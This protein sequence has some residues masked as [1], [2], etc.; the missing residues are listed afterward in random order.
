MAMASLNPFCPA[1]RRRSGTEAPEALL[2]KVLKVFLGVLQVVFRF[3]L[4]SLAFR[5]R[6]Y[7]SGDDVAEPLLSWEKFGRFSVCTS[8][9]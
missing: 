2:K 8:E 6:M 4:L 9:V 7:C 5:L 1:G 3:D